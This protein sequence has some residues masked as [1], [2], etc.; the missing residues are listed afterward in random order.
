[1]WLLPSIPFYEE[2]PNFSLSLSLSHVL[3]T[4]LQWSDG[5]LL[6]DVFLAPYIHYI[7]NTTCHLASVPLPLTKP[8]PFQLINCRWSSIVTLSFAHPLPLTST[9]FLQAFITP[10][11][12][13]GLPAS[14]LSSKCPSLHPGKIIFLKHCCDNV[15]LLLS[16]Q[17]LRE[18]DMTISQDSCPLSSQQ[19]S[20]ILPSQQ[21]QPTF[22]TPLLVLK[23]LLVDLYHLKKNFQSFWPSTTQ[24]Q[25]DFRPYLPPLF[26]TYLTSPGQLKETSCFFFLCW[27]RSIVWK[28]L[29]AFS[30]AFLKCLTGNATCHTH[31]RVVFMPRSFLAHYIVCCLRVG[32]D[33]FSI[34][35]PIR[36]LNTWYSFLQQLF[37]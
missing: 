20:Y 18:W 3:F 19:S 28:V 11:L 21:W 7:W 37:I 12:P 6:L 35:C 10:S 34:L 22:P 2:L 16:I 31:S 8:G 25:P 17:Q 15:Y 9:A 36:M 24:T 27:C 5:T 14:C 26:D 1:M 4:H 32:T 30:E 33:P 29:P 23:R 13:T